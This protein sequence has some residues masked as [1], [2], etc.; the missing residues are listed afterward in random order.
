MNLAGDG[1]R[2]G[3]TECASALCG[4]DERVLGGACVPCEAG[5]INREGDDRRAGDTECEEMPCCMKRMKAMGM[6]FGR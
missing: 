6:T 4:A 3:D 5:L 1:V 2:A